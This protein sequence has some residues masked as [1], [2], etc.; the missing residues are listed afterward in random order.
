[1]FYFVFWL[2]LFSYEFVLYDFGFFCLF[3]FC[4]MCFLRY[5]YKLIVVIVYMRWFD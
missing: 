1:M 5:E 2:E 3:R 4:I